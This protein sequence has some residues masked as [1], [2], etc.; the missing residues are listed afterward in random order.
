[1]KKPSLVIPSITTVP[2]EK[3]KYGTLLDMD[4]KTKERVNNFL[5]EYGELV[6]KHKMD[7]TSYP[8]FTPTGNGLFSV[9]IQSTPVDVTDRL[10][11]LSKT[12]TDVPPSEEFVVTK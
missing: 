3:Q 6:L 1:M 7:F 5:K 9:S 10:E 12:Q 4:E 2:L 8:I 11:E